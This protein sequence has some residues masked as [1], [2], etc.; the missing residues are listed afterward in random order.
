MTQTRGT[1]ATRPLLLAVGL[2]V[3]AVVGACSS[4]SDEVSTG[5][6]TETIV[7]EPA[8]EVGPAAFTPP[9]DTAPLGEAPTGAC[10][11]AAL[12]TQL[13]SRPDAHREWADVLSVPEDQVATYISTL[14][15]RVV[16]ADTRVTNHGLGDDGQAFARQSTLT[17]GT[18]VLVDTST[19]VEVPVTR[20]KCGNPLLP[21]VDV[22]ATTTTTY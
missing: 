11:P 6:T 13:E 9:V 17:T 22:S 12:V 7:V 1:K 16:A 21:P 5:A 4:G 14:E 8:G 20:C 19:G 10:D 18:A 2:A 15:P 3:I